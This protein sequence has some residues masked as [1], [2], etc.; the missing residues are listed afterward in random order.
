MTKR[1]DATR[2]IHDILLLGKDG[3][4]KTEIVYKANLNFPLA[5]KYLHFLLAKDLVHVGEDM[6][7]IR[8]Y[9][10]TDKG[11]RLLGLV[12][13]VE[14]QLEGLLPKPKIIDYP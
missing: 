14:K 9:T 4:T 10:L 6:D 12:S 1:R 7:G 13:E 3:A 11:G 2:V 8:K 5:E